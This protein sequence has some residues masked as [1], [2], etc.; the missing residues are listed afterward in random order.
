MKNSFIFNIRTNSILLTVWFLAYSLLFL[1]EAKADQAV[2]TV[3]D[4]FITDKYDQ[5]LPTEEG[6]K[7]PL[8]L[9]ERGVI[10]YL[11]IL[12]DG[13][14]INNDK[15]TLID[16][17]MSSQKKRMWIIDMKRNEV[18]YY[19]LVAHG[20]NTGDDFA[21]VFSNIRNSNQSSL[22]FYLTGENYYGKHG[23]SL[24]LDGI[25]LGF[26]D[27]ARSRAIVMHSANY[28][29]KDFIKNYGRLGRSFGCPA[30]AVNQHR[31]IIQGLA[32]QSVLFIYYPKEKYEL[33]TQFNDRLKA[34]AY[35]FKSTKNYIKASVGQP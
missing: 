33:G 24:R 25:E 20:K 8:D 35:L 12:A 29:H 17:R 13:I 18:L 23:L 15:L 19:R 27:Q 21:K 32:E 4:Q 11:D 30:I 2:D 9:F 34:E 5:L 26:N 28:V 14:K 16:F 7:P 3:L 10:G 1:S 22:G 6:G 31:E